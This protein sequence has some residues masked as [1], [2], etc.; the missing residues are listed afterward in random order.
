LLT[1][2][3]L[4]SC[5]PSIDKEADRNIRAFLIQAKEPGLMDSE[6]GKEMMCSGLRIAISGLTF[7]GKRIGDKT[8][9]ELNEYTDKCG[10]DRYENK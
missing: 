7:E 4:C 2:L 5:A 9:N 1:L 10:I 3:T 8:L 6:I